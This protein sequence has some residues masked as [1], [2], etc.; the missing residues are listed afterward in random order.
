MADVTAELT[1]LEVLEKL[2]IDKSAASRFVEAAAGQLVA[3]VRT[4][5]PRKSGDLRRGIVASPWEEKTAVPGKV[6]REVFFDWGMNDTFVK[7][8]RAGKRY[9]YPASQEYGFRLT[10]RTS[11]TGETKRVPGKYFMRDSAIEYYPAFVESVETLLEEV[12]GGD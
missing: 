2:R 10:G 12:A 8:S 4:K 11:L 1:G 9:Y 5:A 6:V 3:I 7:Y